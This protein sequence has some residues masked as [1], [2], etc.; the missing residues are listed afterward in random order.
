MTSREVTSYVTTRLNGTV[1]QRSKAAHAIYTQCMLLGRAL[2]R[3]GV[4][5]DALTYGSLVLAALAGVASGTG[6]LMMSANILLLSGL[7]DVL[8]GMVARA[9]GR[10]TKFGALLDSTVDRFADALPL[11]GLV[12]LFSRSGVWAAVPAAAML[13]A[14][15]V[16]YVR[17]RAEGLGGSLPPLF[18][19][20]AERLLML[21]TTL[22]LGGIS[23][24]DG[25]LGS[26]SGV[27]LLIGLGI[28]TALSFVATVAALRASKLVLDRDEESERAALAAPVS[29]APATRRA[30]PDARYLENAPPSEKRPE[31]SRPEPSVTG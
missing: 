7:C 10:S 30:V 2:G 15:S 20:R 4:S 21:F 13:G 29:E 3:H 23:G 1:W 18:M 24:V 17:A 9:T 6:H 11:L 16:S 26:L 22:F 5:P 25:D 28:M 12:A 31:P 27:F 8:D 19:R 14:M